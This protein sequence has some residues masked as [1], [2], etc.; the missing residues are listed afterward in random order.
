MKFLD[1]LDDALL[2]RF[3]PERDGL[4]PLRVVEKPKQ[5]AAK[6]EKDTV[7]VHFIGGQRFAEVQGSTF[8]SEWVNLSISHTSGNREEFL[9]PAD[10]R[11]IDAAN[12]DRDKAEIIKPMWAD[13]LT[14]AQILQRLNGDAEKY[15][16]GLRTIEKYTAAF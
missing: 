11:E 2:G 5:P 4:P 15:G 3:D 7:K 9:T 14:N 16:F 1:T 10:L 13:E 6:S 8:D 12:L